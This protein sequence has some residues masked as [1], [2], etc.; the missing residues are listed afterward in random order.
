[1]SDLF[2]RDIKRIG[3]NS[4]K[5]D[6][7]LSTF[8][9]A[10]VMPLWVADMDFAAPAEITHALIG[11]ATHPI[12]GYTLIPESLY[13]SLIDWLWLRYQWKVER[14]WIILSPGVVPSITTTIMALIQT[15]EQVIIQPPVYFPFFSAVTK[16]DRQLILNPLHLEKGRYTIDFDQLE[17]I[18]IN[19]RMLL[20]CSPHN[21]VG[22]VWSESELAQL[23]KMADKH[24]WVI[25][26]DEIHA[27]LVYPENQHHPLA[28]LTEN[29]ENI[30]TAIAPSK[31]F[32]IP[33]LHL[34]ALIVPN[35]IHRAAIIHFFDMLHVSA[36]N[37]FSMVAFETA[38]RTGATWLN[39]L[40]LYLKNT[41]DQVDGYLA[42]HLPDIQLIKPEGTYLLWLDC[43]ALNMNDKQLKHFFV[44]EAEVG[45]SPG[46]LFGKNGSGFMRMNIGTPRHNIMTALENIRKAYKRVKIR[47]G[48]I[49]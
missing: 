17:Q 8:G 30:I 44:H 9:N 34:S 33:G 15:G 39:E 19:A 2:D 18:G 24:N 20:F 12:Y 13:Q 37:P 10:N 42:E 32:N 3:T 14:E 22:R 35:K 36:A 16:T 47:S 6:G 40:M 45:L 43:R 4:T 25:I 11:R 48:R 38:Y 5:F 31:T 41:R 21:P 49:L 26:S 46:A 1:M 29:P 23:I 28:S 27:D 7:R